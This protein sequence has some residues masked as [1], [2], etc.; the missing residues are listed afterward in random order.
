MPL[1]R[2]WRVVGCTFGLVSM[3]L[4]VSAGS[5]FASASVRFVHAIPG[6]APATLTLSVDGAGVSTAAVS[7]GGASEAVEVD[8]GAANLTLGPADAS[9][10]SKAFAKADQAFE[11]DTAYTVVAL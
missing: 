9:A 3:L 6:G 7:F 11:D 10:D 5:A 1:S 8:P 2:H 4:L